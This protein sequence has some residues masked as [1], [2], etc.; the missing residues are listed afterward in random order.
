MSRP[1]KRP[2]LTLDLPNDDAARAVAEALAKQLA[3][4]QGREILIEVTDQD[5]D[6][7]CIHTEAVVRQ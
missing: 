3:A 7:I 5:G 2:F 4:Q 6:E 1:G